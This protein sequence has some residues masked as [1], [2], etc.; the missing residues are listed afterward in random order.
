VHRALS[1]LEKNRD[2]EVKTSRQNVVGYLCKQLSRSKATSLET[3]TSGIKTLEKR[4]ESDS[5][6]ARK[7]KARP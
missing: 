1:D 3:A 7:P 5:P 4:S 6:V 2:L